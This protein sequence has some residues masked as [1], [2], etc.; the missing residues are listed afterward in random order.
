MS[1]CKEKPDMLIPLDKFGLDRPSSDEPSDLPIS[2]RAPSVSGTNVPFDLPSPWQKTASQGGRGGVSVSK[3]IRSKRGKKRKD[4]N[5]VGS[6]GFSHGESNMGQSVSLESVAPLQAT[7]NRWDASAVDPASPEMV[8]RKVRGLLNELTVEKFDSISDKIIALVNESEKKN[9]GKTLIQV[10]QLVYERA[11]DDAEMYALLCRKIMEQISPLVQDHDYRDVQGRPIAGG[12]LFRKCL[13]NRCWDD[14]ERGCVEWEETVAA[15]ATKALENQVSAKAANDMIEDGPGGSEEIVRHSD[16][17]TATQKAKR[18]QNFLTFFGELFKFRMLTER[19]MHECVKKL[20][21]KV[22]I[23]EQGDLEGLCTLLMSIGAILDTPKARARMDVYISRM[24]ELA[25]SWN[26]S[27]RKQ[28]M[29][30]VR[31]PLSSQTSS[32][33]TLKG[34]H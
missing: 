12:Q 9:N 22:E 15:A 21:G 28:I 18:W 16:E 34:C 10:T 6:H 11:T 8:N 3:S 19:I 30:Q 26:T 31:T 14:F 32:V 20:F 25:K 4:S 17:T 2:G 33:T 27:P 23:P 24:K 29:L 5:Q 1:I 13:L 7:A